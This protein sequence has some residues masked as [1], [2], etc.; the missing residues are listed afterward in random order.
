[1]K[2]R[3]SLEGLLLNAADDLTDAEGTSEGGRAHGLRQLFDHLQQVRAAHRRGKDAEILSEFFDLYTLPPDPELVVEAAE[4]LVGRSL[5]PVDDVE[6]A[7]LSGAVA[8]Y[9]RKS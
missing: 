1:M 4:A 5:S 2:M 7:A 3:C 8:A 6:F 9:R